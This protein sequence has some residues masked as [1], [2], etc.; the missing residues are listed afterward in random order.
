MFE[1]SSQ[2]IREQN[3]VVMKVMEP[4]VTTGLLGLNVAAPSGTMSFTDEAVS[5]L[6]SSSLLARSLLG[7]TT[8]VKRKETVPGNATA[9]R[10]R[11]FIPYEKKDEGYWD[12][13][14]KNNEAA[15]RSRE[16]RRVNDMVLENRVL[17]LLEE[18]ARLRAELLALKFRFGLIK[19]PSNAPILPLTTGT[20]IPQPSTT[21]YYLPRGDGTHHAG[22]T[23][24]HQ[25]PPQ[26][27][28][29]SGRGNR[30]TSSMSEDSGF[31]TPGG[32]SVGSPVF[33]EDRLSDH[34]KLSPHR[35]D[36]L[37]YE[38]HHS[39]NTDGALAVGHVTMSSSRMESVEGIRCLPHK[40][41]FKSPGNGEG[42]NPGD[43]QSP[44]LPVGV[45]RVHS[46]S[47]TSEGS[48]C[49][50]QQDGEETRKVMPQQHCN[51]ASSYSHN[52]NPNES[53]YQVENSMLKS[54]LSSLS[55]QVAQLKKLF[56]EQ[57]LT[58]TN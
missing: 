52:I 7:R 9:R 1:E 13:R 33:F 21:H 57:L 47:G 45:A 22:P 38:Y 37:G 20:C 26:S 15:K 30:E 56:S 3:G 4:A 32:S 28:A 2:E 11:E 27:G 34:G 18:N 54:Q 5:I 40:L 41:R 53:Q 6:T 17:A 58:K 35:A 43:R 29:Q 49:W 55:E 8:A 50:P 48:G 16:K 12:K 10:K 46:L 44:V 31:S 51:P 24:S 23:M 36:E 19:D 39:L 25:S 42:D 14:K